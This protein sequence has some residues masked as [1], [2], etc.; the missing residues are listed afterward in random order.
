MNWKC[1]LGI[2]KLEFKFDVPT[3]F[4]RENLFIC[5]RCSYMSRPS[6]LEKRKWNI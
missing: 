5:K 6:W 1:K 3:C 2:H 4:G